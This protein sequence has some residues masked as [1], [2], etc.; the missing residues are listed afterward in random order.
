VYAGNGV[1]KVVGGQGDDFIF[2]QNGNDTLNG[3]MGDDHVDGGNGVDFLSGN[4]GNDWLSGGQGKDTLAGGTDNGTAD[5]TFEATDT[6]GHSVPVLSDNAPVLANDAV[7]TTGDPGTGPN[8]VEEGVY[9]DTS[10]A[11]DTISHVFSFTPEDVGGDGGETEFTVA[12]FDADGSLV[13]TFD[14]K[15]TE[16]VKNY[17]SLIDN[18]AVDDGGTVA[19]FTA[20][21]VVPGTLAEVAAGTALGTE[22]YQP[23]TLTPVSVDITA[24]DELFGG[25]GNDTFVYNFGDGVDV[26]H[27]YQK[28]DV[29]E[30]H[31]INPS[32]VKTVVENGN[33]IILF[34]D[35]AGGF[36]ANS[37]I[38]LVGFTGQP[39]LLF[40]L[41]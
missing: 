10:T 2:G 21:T 29:I 14:L 16:G 36:A 1:D 19:V 15:M 9:I 37:A 31:G 3:G 25:A 27:D 22:A 13:D 20:G 17:F 24:G 11:P 6:D 34:G 32:D 35:G 8:L 30:L 23:V 4:E 7:P 33:T 5:V 39:H 38:E 12:V 28:G 18:D 41:H 26:I 40:D